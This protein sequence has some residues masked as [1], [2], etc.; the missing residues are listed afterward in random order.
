MLQTVLEEL[1][2]KEELPSNIILLRKICQAG[3]LEFCLAVKPDYI[4]TKFHKTIANKLQKF[5]EE[6]RDGKD[7]N[8]MLEMQPQIGKSTLVSEL[9]P[10]WVLGKEAWPV[11]VAS[12][13]SDLAQQKSSNC[14]D[15]VNSDV[16]QM[17]FPDS[18]LN[19]ET[20]A[21][22]YWKTTNGGCL[23]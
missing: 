5:Y 8:I 22:D 9:F 21:K 14:R 10:A 4:A 23:Y 11:I 12:Y 16:Y 20:A 17:I 2:K 19:P 18:K 3:F 15:I 1:S 13:G 7:Q 6:V